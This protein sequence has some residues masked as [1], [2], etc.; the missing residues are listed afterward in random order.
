MEFN[1]SPDAVMHAGDDSSSSAGQQP[2]ELEAV[3]G[4]QPTR[5]TLRPHRRSNA[6][7]DTIEPI[8][9]RSASNL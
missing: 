1:P 8:P 7:D 9:D 5:M 4:S 6:A 2:R 3:A